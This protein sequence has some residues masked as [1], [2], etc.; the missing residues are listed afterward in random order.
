VIARLVSFAL[1]LGALAAPAGGAMA[2]DPNCRAG[3]K[4]VL[5]IEL[6]FGRNIGGKL[7][8]S[9]RRWSDFLVR[10]I[11]PWFPDGLTVTDALGQWRDRENGKIVREK[12]KIVMLLAAEIP[13]TRESVEAVVAA[14][15]KRFNQQSVGVVSRAA[16][17]AF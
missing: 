4:P 9:D 17:A 14:Y 5:R 3:E 16:C 6:M 8:V 15:K 11:T 12:S 2:Q 13:Q 10:E 1:A 7:G